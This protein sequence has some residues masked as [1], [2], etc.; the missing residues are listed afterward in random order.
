MLTARILSLEMLNPGTAPGFKFS[1]KLFVA[2]HKS[3]TPI[4]S[5]HWK[6][7]KL[8]VGFYVKC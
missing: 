7:I 1:E 8:G 2:V 5:L 4:L 3:N 6:L